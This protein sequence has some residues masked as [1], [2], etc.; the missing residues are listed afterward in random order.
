MGTA[1]RGEFLQLVEGYGPISALFGSRYSIASPR[2]SGTS[3]DGRRI[4]VACS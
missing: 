2:R 3:G 4:F 1:V